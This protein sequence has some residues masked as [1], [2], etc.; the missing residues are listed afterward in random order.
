MGR[1]CVFVEV[2]CYKTYNNNVIGEPHAKVLYNFLDKAFYKF[3]I[4]FCY[5]Y[6]IAKLRTVKNI[7]RILYMVVKYHKESSSRNLQS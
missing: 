7:Q 2:S 6:K 3:S 1:V 4:N 5:E